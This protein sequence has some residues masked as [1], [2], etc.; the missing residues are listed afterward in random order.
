MAWPG[1]LSRTGTCAPTGPLPIPVSD[2]PLPLVELPDLA[3]AAELFDRGDAVAARARLEKARP[4]VPPERQAL[5]DYLMARCDAALGAPEQAVVTLGALSARL[6]E[7]RDHL[8]TLRA[9]AALA[10]GRP[11]V[12][13]AA[14]DALSAL[15]P[16]DAPGAYDLDLRLVRRALDQ[17]R[18]EDA[19]R[20]LARAAK[21]AGNVAERGRVALTLA[22]TAFA[23]HRDPARRHQDLIEIYRTFSNT[24]AGRDARDLLAASGWPE[25]LTCGELVDE[26]VADAGRR[27]PDR[28]LAAL[29]RSRCG[30]AVSGLPE[31]LSLLPRPRRLKPTRLKQLDQLIAGRPGG[32]VL[33]HLY[34]ERARHLR[35]VGRINE[36]LVA[37]A[38][39]GDHGDSPAQ[40]GQ[41]YFEGA[42]LA[43]KLNQVAGAE[44]MVDG[45]VTWLDPVRAAQNHAHAL[46]MQ[47]WLAWRQG[48]PAEAEALWRR[49][50]DLHAESLDASKRPFYE[51]ATY[52]RARALARM[53][54]D[55]HAWRLYWHLRARAPLS[56]Y[57]VLAHARLDDGN[58]LVPP[59][60]GG[61]LSEAALPK[62][63]PSEAAEG[64]WLYRLGLAGQAREQ[65]RSRLLRGRL[66]PE[67]VLLLSRLYAEEAERARAFWVVEAGDPLD[68]WPIGADRNRWL[69][70]FPRPF[71]DPVER[72]SAEA[73]V[74]PFLVWAVMRQE[75]A[76]KVEAQS[77][78]RA[79]G[80]MQ[81]LLSTARDMAVRLGEPRPGRKQVL[82][83]ETNVRYGATYLRRVLD[84]YDGN[85]ALALAAYNAGAGNVDD[86]LDR[87]GDL[88][89]D[90]FVEEIPF[91]EARG[92]VRKV[93]RSYAA[94]RA[95]YDE[96]PALK[97]PWSLPG[98]PGAPPPPRP[99]ASL[100]L[101]E[102]GSANPQ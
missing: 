74:D 72:A 1:P 89:G 20:I 76:F 86:W 91:D 14:A 28:R 87:L 19:E 60:F 38:A 99:P 35:R 55:L 88:E 8:H 80:L 2:D 57:G 46:W 34:W 23:Q 9:E 98:L 56:Y 84:R 79:L 75:S 37:Y 54:K 52:W 6:P 85:P 70:A 33:G 36:A 62:T 26:A 51:R 83:A 11:V 25:P 67:G 31:L 94:Y 66:R 53:G 63:V 12:D 73:R 102:R 43:R 100:V 61:R 58:P 90:E 47:G 17:R 41:A 97:L 71:V 13:D 39:A 50:G 44:A 59:D 4:Q 32:A 78:A 21:R 64:L 42:R 48:H 15:L 93:L 82:D 30:N 7:L 45:A 101:A 3:A 24:S 77:H 95:L 81:L 5:F 68:V 40:R 18:F 16:F 65:L 96:D 92:Y 27:L 22:G 10:Q 49:L 69:A 29:A